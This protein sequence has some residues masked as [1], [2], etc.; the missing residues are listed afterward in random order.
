M[1]RVSFFSLLLMAVSAKS[2]V[3]NFGNLQVHSGTAVTIFGN[4]NNTSSASLINNGDVYLKGDLSNGQP[5]M[6]AG[7]G[8]YYFSGTIPQA[9][10][11]TNSFKLN[12]LVS[13]NSA[14][15]TLNNNLHINGFHTF[16]AGIISSASSTNYLVYESGSDH[17]GSSDS[18]H[19]NGWVKKVG[20]TNFVFPV[21]NGTVERRIGLSDLN[22]NS[23]FI[24]NYSQPTANTT[25]LG[26]GMLAVNVSEFWN[27]QKISGGSAVVDMNWADNKVAF[28]D[29]PT[30]E[31]TTAR[32]AGGSWINSGG[33][34]T[35]DLTTGTISSDPTSEFTQ[36]TLGWEGVLLPLTLVDF[37]ATHNG[38]A[39]LVQW[40]TTFEEGL[41]H[42]AVER[43]DDG[44]N[45]ITLGHVTARNSANKEFYFFSDTRPVE[46]K[47]WYRLRC[48]DRNGRESMS[49]TVLVYVKT[50]DQQLSLFTNPV[51]RSILLKAS[52]P[53]N[54]MFEYRICYLNGQQI[55]EGKMSVTNA[56]IYE[57]PLRSTLLPGLYLLNVKNSKSSFQYKLIKR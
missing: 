46:V 34:P 32:Y 11:G 37:S 33:I 54:T 25:Q 43:S 2:Q 52:Q 57:I 5:L 44:R 50:N 4:L 56:G 21:G 47:A 10:N 42:F 31:I 24:V 17:T 22:S 20:N 30:S 53:F 15:I 12:N 28:P 55:Q 6:S 27:I 13:N 48:V 14:G 8:T 51:D 40:T 16:T 19:V 1:K 7:A 26:A 38:L 9:V 18:K 49:K 23:E 29:W 3:T 35:G 41:S 45:F 39:T 36:F